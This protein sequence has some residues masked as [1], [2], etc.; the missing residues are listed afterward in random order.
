ME[1]PGDGV[2]LLPL[3]ICGYGTLMSSCFMSCDDFLPNDLSPISVVHQE[4]IF[5]STGLTEP[6]LKLAS[7]ESDESSLS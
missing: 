2:L 6:S 7:L 4:P 3:L 5:T 1:M